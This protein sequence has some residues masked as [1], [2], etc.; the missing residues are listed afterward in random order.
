M[1]YSTGS[2]SVVDLIAAILAHAVADGWTTTGGTWPI[3][4]GNVRG[5]HLNTTTRNVTTYFN[6]APAA[7][8]ET[9][10]RIGIGETPAAAT[11]NATANPV[12]VFNCNYAIA[13]W[14]IFSD[15]GVGKP[16]HIHVVTRFS[17]GVDPEVFNHF[18]FGELEKNGLSYRAVVYAASHA[19]RGYIPEAPGNQNGGQWSKDWNCGPMDNHPM[20]MSGQRSR[21]PNGTQPYVTGMGLRYII[22]STDPPCLAANGWPALDVIQDDTMLLQTGSLF[23]SQL[24]SIPDNIILTSAAYSYRF[25]G[26]ASLFRNHPFSGGVTMQAMPFVLLNATTASARAMVLGTFPNIRLCN[27]ESYLP[28]DEILYGADRWMI[29]PLLK[30][31]PFSAMNNN[32]VVSSGQCALAYKKVE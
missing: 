23:N 14:H 12:Q 4:K 5:V 2:G 16:D 26:Q 6:S 20:Y 18:S 3:S 11:A 31:T 13:D 24:V 22:D 28:K 32:Q 8:T 9:I 10:L 19:R 1:A 17:N 25:A 15:P 27:M 21:N 7:M 30:R 29:T